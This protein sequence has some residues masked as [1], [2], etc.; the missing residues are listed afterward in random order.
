MLLFW[1]QLSDT[2]DKSSTLWLVVNTNQ[3]RPIVYPSK[4]HP[5][6]SSLVQIIKV[7]KRCSIEEEVDRLVLSVVVYRGT[8]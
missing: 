3:K 2:R 7:A 5:R 4:S 6:P 8:Q 1:Y